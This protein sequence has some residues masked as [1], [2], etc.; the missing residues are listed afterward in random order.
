MSKLSTQGFKYFNL[1][2]NYILKNKALNTSYLKDY[3]FKFNDNLNLNLLNNELQN[4][5]QNMSL[6]NDHDYLEDL[7]HRTI[8]SVDNEAFEQSVKSENSTISDI[9]SIDEFVEENKDLQR[10]MV[11]SQS[12]NGLSTRG[13]TQVVKRGFGD[14]KKGIFAGGDFEELVTKSTI[15]MDKSLFV[16]E[17]M[18]DGNK[19]ILITMPRRWGKSLNLDMLKRFLEIQVDREGNIINPEDSLNYKMFNGNNKALKPLK[20]SNT[21]IDIQDKEGEHIKVD[22]KELQ[23]QFPVIAVDFKDCKGMNFGEVSSR[24]KGKILKTIKQF[25]YLSNSSKTHEEVTIGESYKILLEEVKSGN[26]GIGLQ[27]LSELLHTHHEQKTWI[28][29]DEYDA[30]ANKAY[31]E[32][33]DKEA[34]QVAELF[35]SVYEPALKENPHLEKGVMTGVQYIVKS[36]M[37]SGLNNLKNPQDSRIQYS[38]YYGINKKEMNTLIEHFGIDTDKANQIKD[39]YNGYSEKVQNEEKTY[40]D[41]YNIWSVVNYL[42]AYCND[43][44]VD[45]ISYWEK[46]GSVDS[47][48]NPILKNEEFKQSL[49]GLVNGDS[50]RV[51]NLISDFSV[52]NFNLLKNMTNKSEV[53]EINQNGLDLIFSYLFITGYLTSEGY[54][55]LK[56]PNKE[57]KT[58]FESKLRECYNEI[59]LSLIHI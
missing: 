45:F 20:I 11:K 54:T 13:L 34:Q 17:V 47:F 56:L 4:K 58:E 53:I 23:G 16:K 8:Y 14:V 30:A 29:I 10:S 21:T 46:S 40:I 5:L 32:F 52:E 39:W 3:G 2:K 28:L 22:P 33:D 55:D 6:L 36:G 44:T 12:L 31:M 57:I 25:A 59:F 18:E 50:I 7:Y 26:I 48:L 9:N 43:K 51:T 27:T 37:L 19:V 38:K 35:R 42:N 41:K 1:F 49:E 15:F 24:L